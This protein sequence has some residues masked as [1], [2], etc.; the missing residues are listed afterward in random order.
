MAVRERPCHLEYGGEGRVLVVRIADLGYS[1][2][3]VLQC[4]PK[5]F[6]HGLWGYVDTT[7]RLGNFI[8]EKN[9]PV[10]AFSPFRRLQ[11]MGL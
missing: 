9:P 7:S 3:P 4:F 8:L 6:E 2:P 1:I 11:M 5:P 10:V